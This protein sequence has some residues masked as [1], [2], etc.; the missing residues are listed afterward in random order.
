[1]RFLSILKKTALTAV[2]YFLFVA[3]AAAQHDACEGYYT[4]ENIDTQQQIVDYLLEKYGNRPGMI[5]VRGCKGILFPETHKY[6]TGEYNGEYY[7]ALNPNMFAKSAF[8]ITKEG[9]ISFN[10]PENIKWAVQ[11][12]H[13]LGHALNRHDLNASGAK[14]KQQEREADKFAGRMLCK[15]ALK[16]DDIETAVKILLQANSHAQDIYDDV[17]KRLQ[18]FCE[19]YTQEGCKCKGG[20]TPPIAPTTEQM[21][22]ALAE[23]EKDYLVDRE[24]QAF[25]I[26]FKFRNE[27]FFESKHQYQL[28]WM[29][30]NGKGTPQ[31]NTEAVKWYRK[32]AE[33]GYAKAQFSLGIMYANG[34]GVEQQSGTEAVKWYRNAAEQGHSGAQCNL[35]FMYENGKGVMK[36]TDIAIDLYKKAAQQGSTVGKKNFQILGRKLLLAALYSEDEFTVFYKYRNETFFD[37]GNQV[38]LGYMYSTGK[39]VKQDYEEAVKWYRKAAEQGNDY[40]QN[41]LAWMYEHGTGVERD[42]KIAVALYQKAA[43]QGNHESQKSLKEIG[44]SW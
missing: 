31:S 16:W 15:I 38:K 32:A 30:D 9:E 8:N 22:A 14:R 28:G 13:E 4:D 12:A 3:M 26:Y 40:G 43:R 25:P 42:M 2:T 34:K 5:R 21:I 29:Y 23:A 35:G 44:L 7:I 6:K 24:A 11:L 41:N 20:D 37:S 39:G 19:G 18:Q 36:D 1:M 10:N 33:L 17:E 27:A